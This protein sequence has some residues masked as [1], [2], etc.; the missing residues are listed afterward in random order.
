MRLPVAKFK[1]ERDTALF[2]NL[3]FI[4]CFDMHPTFYLLVKISSNSR[5]HPNPDDPRSGT[6][7]LTLVDNSSNITH[8]ASNCQTHLLSFQW[9]TSSSNQ[10]RP[11]A[12][13]GLLFAVFDDHIS[14]LGIIRKHGKGYQVD[15]I[16]INSHRRNR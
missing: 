9:R 13:D 11:L 10:L 4:R 12:E 8:N 6:H 5:I 3:T 14:H 15:S 1:Y 16:S 7:F 2:V